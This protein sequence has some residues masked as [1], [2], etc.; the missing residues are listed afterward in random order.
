MDPIPQ[1]YPADGAVPDEV[2]VHDHEHPLSGHRHNSTSIGVN[3]AESP[4]TMGL[5][6]VQNL[7]QSHTQTV[8]A[9]GDPKQDSCKQGRPKLRQ[10]DIEE[11]PQI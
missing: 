5:S 3:V 6:C 10:K 9:Y 1:A 2:A 8:G 11:Q 4:P 7:Q